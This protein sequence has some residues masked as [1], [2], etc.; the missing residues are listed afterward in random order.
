MLTHVRTALGESDFKPSVKD[1]SGGE[2]IFP[3]NP[4]RRV[5]V[6]GKKPKKPRDPR[7]VKAGNES[8]VGPPHLYALE[9]LLTGPR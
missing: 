8:D 2:A 3:D 6:S 1:V 9:V 4:A 7:A 5:S